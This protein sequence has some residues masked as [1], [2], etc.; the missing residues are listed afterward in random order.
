VDNEK[1]SGCALK[2][3]T[4]LRYAL[5]IHRRLKELSG[6]IGT[7]ECSSSAYR[8]RRAWVFGSTAKG[9][10]N[11]RDLDV[12]VD[13]RECGRRQFC[14]WKKPPS[15]ENGRRW[16]CKINRYELRA[17]RIAQP[18]FSS[19]T[20]QAY[21]RRGLPMVRFH[22]ENSEGHIAHP[23]I[24]IYPR[25]D[26]EECAG[27]KLPQEKHPVR[28]KKD[29]ARN[30]LD[31]VLKSRKMEHAVCRDGRLYLGAASDEDLRLSAVLTKTKSGEW[32]A[33]GVFERDDV[34]LASGTTRADVVC[35]VIEVLAKPLG[36][37]NLEDP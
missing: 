3:K 24:M 34:L 30:R 14:K 4:A 36:N 1:F 18:L 11:P 8:V 12:L 17:H 21:L 16:E 29:L 28:K 33:R 15:Y 31:S 9:S 32:E 35:G 25:F 26:F 20:A 27:W 7:P 10:E 13:D 5:T 23:R 19:C 22:S 2:R 6:L 37:Q